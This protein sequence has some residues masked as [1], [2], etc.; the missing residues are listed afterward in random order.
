[1]INQQSFTRDVKEELS[2][3]T[4]ESIDRLKALLSAYIK[5]NG[6]IVFRNKKTLL[7]LS[8]ENAKIAKFIY[9]SLTSTYSAEIHL[10]FKKKRNSKK[11]IYI[12]S[13]ESKVDEIL[14]DLNIDFLEGKIPKNIVFNDDS[15][16]GYLAGAFLSSGSVN[17]PE[18][19]NYH[20]E[21]ALSNENFA[22]WLCKLFPRY[23]NSNL[24]PKLIKRREKYVVYFKKSDQIAV[25]LIMIGAVNS[26]MDF[27][28]FRTTRDFTNSNNRTLNLDTANMSKIIKTG[29]RQCKEI[30]VINSKLGIKNISNKKI[31][32][33]CNLRLEHDSASLQELTD[34]MN[35]QLTK[36]VTKSNINHLFRKIHEMYLGLNK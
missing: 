15:I 6:V 35:E 2:L 18:T 26:C 29:K 7:T 23:K 31:A 14:S 22:K 36:P 21:I 20:L 33:L 12:V 16:S 32:I 8:T 19:S 30:N 1:M 27:E 34:L 17:S 25:F 9:Q 10:N 28:T 11:N 3:N 5:I 4:Y 24:T 13:I